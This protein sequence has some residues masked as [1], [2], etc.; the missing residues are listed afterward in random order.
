MG[1]SWSR[2]Q[3]FRCLCSWAFTI[4]CV[5]GLQKMGEKETSMFNH[6]YLHN[7]C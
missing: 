1:Y 6:N 4:F 2:V 7:V 5:H 3:S